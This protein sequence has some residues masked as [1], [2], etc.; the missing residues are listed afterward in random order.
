[1]S[2]SKTRKWLKTTVQLLFFVAI[3]SGGLVFAKHFIDTKP[4]VKRSRPLKQMPR[5]DVQPVRSTSKTVVL[6]AM[7]TVI[8]SRKISLTSDL[9]GTVVWVSPNFVPGGKVKKGDTLIKLDKIDYELAVKKQQSLVQQLQADLDLEKGQQAVARKEM[10]LMQK[11][12]KKI[13]KDPKLA[14]RVPQLNKALA[15]LKSQLIGL[16]QAQL[17][18]KRTTITAPFNAMILDRTIELGS[19]I[20]TQSALATLTDTDTFWIEAAV[21]VDKLHWIRIPGVNGTRSSRVTVH[22]QDGSSADGQVVR[23]LGDLSDKSQ[24]ARLLVQVDDPF[25]TGKRSGSMPL[26]LNSYVSLELSGSIIKDVIEIPRSAVREGNRILMFE[27]K[28]LIIRTINPIWEDE[29]YLYVKNSIKRGELLITS[30]MST[31]VNG[32]AVRSLT[33]GKVS[34][35]IADN[36]NQFTTGNQRKRDDNSFRGQ[37][38]K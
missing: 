14:L 8:S 23:L 13:I 29:S 12:L 22:L 1:M 9:S 18:L 19:R 25:S 11:T 16:E 20:T 17:N 35:R 28:Q 34:T 5:V 21:P 27:E 30:E 6:N 37:E 24:M 7:G 26:L 33:A 3:I 31:A 4:R 10:E 15:S 2:Q 32:M 36:R 38:T